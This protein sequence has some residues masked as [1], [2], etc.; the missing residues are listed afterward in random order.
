MVSFENYADNFAI[1]GAQ[2][3]A[4]GIGWV[5]VEDGARLTLNSLDSIHDD[6]RLS[7]EGFAKVVIPNSNHVETVQSMWVGGIDVG[8]GTFDASDFPNNIEGLGKIQVYRQM[9]ALLLILR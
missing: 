3:W 2:G 1:D 5:I 4:L 7:I 9:D 6:A 8:F